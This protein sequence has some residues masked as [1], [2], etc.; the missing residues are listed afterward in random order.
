MWRRPNKTHE[1]SMNTILDRQV[2]KW[3]MRCIYDDCFPLLFRPT[4]E[5][6][7]RENFLSQIKPNKDHNLPQNQSFYR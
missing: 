5:N 1:M 4:E 2:R 7:V 3:L 6:T